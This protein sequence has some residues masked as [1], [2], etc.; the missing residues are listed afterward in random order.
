[1]ETIRQSTRGAADVTITL[2]GSDAEIVLA[3]L[4]TVSH[5]ASGEGEDK[6]TTATAEVLDA[7]HTIGEQVYGAAPGLAC[8]SSA[9]VDA[10]AEQLRADVLT[11]VHRNYKQTKDGLSE[12]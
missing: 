7:Y 12:R 11:I 6:D 4:K 8:W 9:V 2:S 1:M 5:L 3:A 10:L